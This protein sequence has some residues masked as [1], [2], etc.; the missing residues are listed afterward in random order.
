MLHSNNLPLFSGQFSLR[1]TGSAICPAIFFLCRLSVGSLQNLFQYTSFSL[2]QARHHTAFLVL[3]THKNRQR[4]LFIPAPPVLKFY[5]LGFSCAF[6][7]SKA[8]KT[9]LASGCSL[10]HSQLARTADLRNRRSCSQDFNRIPKKEGNHA[11]NQRC[12]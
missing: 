6:S 8:G 2:S 3:Q 12:P 7:V 10:P 11:G 4:R 9:C 1:K 5:T